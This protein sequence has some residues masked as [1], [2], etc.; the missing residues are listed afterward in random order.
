MNGVGYPDPPL[1]HFR[2]TEIWHTAR[3]DRTAGDGWLGRAFTAPREGSTP[4]ATH[5]V[6]AVAFDRQAP[7]SFSG[8]GSNTLTLRAFG[9]LRL[10]A[11]I[12]DVDVLYRAWS[13]QPGV[14]GQVGRA[15]HAAWETARS[16]AALKPAKEGFSGRL[17]ADLAQALSLLDARL[18]VD[19]LQLAFDGFDTHANQAEAH[20]RLLG[21]LGTNLRAFQRGV[22]ARGLGREVVCVVFSEFGRRPEENLSAGTDHGTAGPVFVLGEQVR[23]GLH[24]A[25]PSLDPHHL[26]NENLRFTTDFRRIYAALLEGPL[27]LD[28]HPLIG[29]HE[30]L[31]LWS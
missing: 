8:A 18:G 19:V 27:A 4:S 26:V 31:D 5:G 22:E 30:P 24:G 12:R 28:P 7:Q 15:G 16:I 23:A 9:D 6:R 1:S 11:R 20:A 10:P 3:P 25:Q 2:A 13:S 21:E 29:S 14:R 17:G